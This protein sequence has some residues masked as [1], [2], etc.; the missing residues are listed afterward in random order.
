MCACYFSSDAPP[1]YGCPG[2]FLNVVT[3]TIW[4]KQTTMNIKRIKQANQFNVRVTEE[5]LSMLKSKAWERNLSMSE[6]VRGLIGLEV[7]RSLLPDE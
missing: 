1:A 2:V 6:Y 5:E 7:R 3:R 4:R